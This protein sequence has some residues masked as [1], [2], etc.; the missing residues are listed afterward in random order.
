MLLHSRS[1]LFAAL[2]AV[3]ALALPASAEDAC[4]ADAKRLCS[5]VP[6]GSGRVYFCLRSSWSQL[7]DGCQQ[8]LDWA[9]KRANEVALDC[10]ADAF[11][12][13]QGVPAGK[14]RLFACLAG[15]RDQISS[16]CT[17]ALAAVDWFNSACGADRERLC[18]GVPVVDGGAIACLATARERL[19][20]ACQAVFWP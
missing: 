3:G 19:S 2:L 14:G 16:E 9:Q 18:S 1:M 17:K 4:L 15:H 5:T 8:L 6:P 10:Q 12:W 20:P 7:S 13:C 11:A